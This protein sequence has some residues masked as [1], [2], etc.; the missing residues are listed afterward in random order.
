MCF[1]VWKMQQKT[2]MLRGKGCFHFGKEDRYVMIHDVCM[3]YGIWNI[4]DM[5]VVDG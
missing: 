5:Y 3:I 2:V 1:I 4:F